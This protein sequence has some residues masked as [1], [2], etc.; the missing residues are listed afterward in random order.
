[1]DVIFDLAKNIVD[2]K[3]EY[4]S[5]EA[6]K[7]AKK[8]II[9]SIGV[10]IAGSGAPGNATIIELIKEWAGKME[11][12]II[13]YGLQ[14][15]APEAAFANS[16]FIHS[17][18]FDDTYDQTA[19]HV[20][21]TVLPAALAIGEKMG[22]TGKELIT[23]VIL[24]IDLICRLAQASNLFHGWHN[25]STVG[26]FGA[27]AATGKLLKLNQA[28]MVNALGIAYS[29]ASGNR[30]GR[31]DGALTKRLQPAFSTKAGLISALFAQKGV[32]GAQNV[33]QGEWGFFRLY[34]D[35][36]R[37]YEPDKWKEV[38]KGELGTRYEV[39][40]LGAKPY[41]CVRCAH[42]PIDG[43]LELA[44]KYNI[45]PEDVEEVIVYTNGRVVETAGR[46]FIIR[47]D[48]LVDAQ[49]SIPYT[50][51]VA[52]TKKKVTLADFQEEN[53]RNVELNQLANKVKVVIDPEFKDSRSVVGPIKIKIK[54]KGGKEFFHKVDLAKGHSKNSMSELELNEKFKDCVKYSAKPI[55]KQNIEQLL[56]ILYELEK[57]DDIS[58]VVRLMT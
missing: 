33:I 22:N 6:V 50:V 32:T 30:Q 38:L 31:Q 5:Q 13:V 2:T 43:A 16:V 10:G 25:T 8:F 20:N 48:P 28:Q 18:D 14:V 19:T 44:I 45:K 36:S 54:M 57:V 4:L 46:P 11:S 39:V 53:I 56:M 34:R 26:V 58:K 49:F 27:A 21:V 7:I 23:A 17:T 9:D 47:T 37:E 42:A 12:T 29:Q 24:G 40:N 55:S 35:Y 51:A 3:Y 41:P 15:P 52:V 1:M